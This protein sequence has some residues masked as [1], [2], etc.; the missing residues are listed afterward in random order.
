MRKILFLLLFLTQISFAQQQA[1]LSGYV[2]NSDGSPAVYSTVSLKGTKYVTQTDERGKYSLKA[3]QGDYILMVNMIGMEVV[4]KQIHLNTNTLELPSISLK[5]VSNN[6]DEVSV[7][8]KTETQRLKE[9]PIKAEIIDMKPLQIEAATLTESMNRAS[10]VRIRQ[11]GGLG[12]Q[13]SVAVNGFTGKSVK[14]FKDDIPLDYLGEGFNINLIP[15]N[16]LDRVEI[17]KGVL[18]TNL[19]ADALGGAVNYVTKSSVKNFV[20][21]SYE[22]ASFNTHRASFNLYRFSDTSKIFYGADV[23]FN[24][25]DNNYKVEAKVID[26]ETATRLPKEVNRFHDKFTN[27]FAEIFGGVKNTIWADELRV[28]ITAFHTYRQVQ[29]DAIMST[30]FGEI[31]TLQNGIVPT[32]RYKKSVLNN[33]LIIDQFFVYSILQNRVIDTCNCQYDWYGNKKYIQARN[34]EADSDGSLSRVNFNNFTS[35]TNLNYLLGKNLKVEFNN[36]ISTYSRT[37][38]DPFGTVY[39]YSQRD[40]LSVPAGYTKWVSALGLTSTFFKERL[41]NTLSVKQY[42]YNTHGTGGAFASYDENPTTQKNQNYGIVEALKF[43]INENSFIR[44]SIEWAYRL[45]EQGE[46]FGDG[47]FLLSNFK[48]QPEKSTNFNVGYRIDKPRKISIEPNIFYRVTRDQII[49]VPENLI[50]LQ[51]QNVEQTRGYG[52]EVDVNYFPAKWL[53]LFGN[54]TYQDLRLFGLTSISNRFLE[55]ARLRNTPYFFSNSGIKTDF[56]NKIMRDDAIRIFWYFSY[57]HEYYLSNI[58]K[59]QEAPNL[60]SRPAISTDLIIPTQN[61]HSAGINYS[62]KNDKIS[63]GLEVKNIFNAMLFDNFRVQRAGRSFHIKL[64]YLIN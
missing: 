11:T 18:P 41:T 60:W 32:L 52:L 2:I 24:H 26:P 40:I 22:H 31:F 14:F 47:Q 9:E 6:L 13:T 15:I 39:F 64:R 51:Y 19:G 58:P 53:Q 1:F 3:P 61:L 25:S 48:L 16:M 43:K 23:F 4:E 30:P 12:S 49:L 54:I 28:G 46:V 55:D 63:L 45:P 59:S 5:A 10:G 44:G 8:G 50:Y 57:T 7:Q 27:G 37:G 36:V 38:S 62:L 34:G 42:F 21:L 33:K 29:N 35:R 17:Y 20:D 56:K